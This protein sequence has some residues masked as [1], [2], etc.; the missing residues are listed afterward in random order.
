MPKHTVKEKK[1]NK[2]KSLLAKI[3]TFGARDKAAAAP[4]E[5]FLDTK[6]K[7]EF[8]KSFNKR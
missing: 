2:A 7:K 5:K 4:R 8:K 1:K 6:K 3:M